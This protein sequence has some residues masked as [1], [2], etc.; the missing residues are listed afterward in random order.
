MGGDT[1]GT[2]QYATEHMLESARAV[3]DAAA[4]RLLGRSRMPF[5]ASLFPAAAASAAPGGPSAAPAARVFC[6][7]AH[8]T[9]I[10]GLEIPR[11][12]VPPQPYAL[13]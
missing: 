6:P 9:A 2:V 12:L 1:A 4:R 13:F 11:S 5:I 7:T 10:L 8:E 3:P